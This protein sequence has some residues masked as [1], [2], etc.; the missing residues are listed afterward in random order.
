MKLLLPAICNPMQLDRFYIDNFKS[1]VDF[2]LPLS[3]LTCLIGLNGSGKSTVIQ[4]LDFAARM[5]HGDLTGWLEQR[6]W[7]AADLN[8]RLVS[9]SNIG[10]C[11]EVQDDKHRWSWCGSFNRSLLRCTREQL[12]LDGT[13]LFQVAD[14]SILTARSQAS[15]RG[16][17]AF[18]Y[19]G[20][21]LSALNEEAL[22]DET[23]WRFRD[24]MQGVT[25]LDLLA[26]EALKRRTHAS[27]GGLGLGGERLSAF[28]YELPRPKRDE[29]L[30]MLT[31]CYP[32]LE[33]IVSQ[34]LRGGW[35][36]LYVSERYDKGRVNTHA[37]HLNDGMLRL[38][39]I[40]AETL[41]ESSFL[42]FD[43]IEN[44]INPEL[45]EFLLDTLLDAPQQILVTTHSPMILNFLEDDVA[46]AGVQYLYRT[47]DGR[48]RSIPFFSIPSLNAKLAVMGPGEAFVDTELSRLPEEIAAMSCQQAV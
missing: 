45:V 37:R 24:F 47:E 17:I 19:Q 38:M 21:V 15:A 13:P 22:P 42:L 2:A 4:G 1:L 48:S 43:E 28:L 25:A 31:R 27:S 16:F 10:L 18:K 44:G 26:P 35:K 41:T 39:A 40:L 33:Q 20:S 6:S 46:R 30:N 8:S 7:K 3:K 11:V 12:H 36:D 5:F 23:I 9:K 29:L 14:G 34:S 32:Q